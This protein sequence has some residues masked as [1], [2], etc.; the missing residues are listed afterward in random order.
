[1]LQENS[2][3]IIH[4]FELLSVDGGECYFKKMADFLLQKLEN[5]NLYWGD[6]N[7][8]NVSEVRSR[9]IAA[10]RKAD[11]GDYADLLNFTMGN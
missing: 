3:E 2:F 7:L 9:Y 1:M 11:A 5:K 6:T 8:V 10:L 4:L